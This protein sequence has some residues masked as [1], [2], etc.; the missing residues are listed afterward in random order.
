MSCRLAGCGH[1]RR[2]GVRQRFSGADGFLFRIKRH[3]ESGCGRLQNLHPLHATLYKQGLLCPLFCFSVTIGFLVKGFCSMH[4]KFCVISL[5]TDKV[6]WN[7][8][9]RRSTP[10]P[11]TQ[12]VFGPGARAQY[13][14]WLRDLNADMLVVVTYSAVFF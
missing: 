4:L 3:A 10:V 9:P 6:A 1:Q 13:V 5:G 12:V 14:G 11:L 2:R 8:F 7:K